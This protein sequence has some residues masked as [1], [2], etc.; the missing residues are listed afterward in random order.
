MSAKAMG[1]KG[2]Q[3]NPLTPEELARLPRPSGA[4]G[5]NRPSGWQSGPILL[6]KEPSVTDKK[7]VTTPAPTVPSD[8]AEM[9]LDCM[10]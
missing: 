1:T 9:E 6:S 7:A 4:G 10:D 5:D 8:A 2:T 3:L